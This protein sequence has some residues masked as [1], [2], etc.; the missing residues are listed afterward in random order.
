MTQEEK[1]QAQPAAAVV[2]EAA[3]KRRAWCRIPMCAGDDPSHRGFGK[4]R[5]EAGPA[6]VLEQAIKH[7]DDPQL[8]AGQYG[9]LMIDS[10]FGRDFITRAAGTPEAYLSAV[11]SFSG[12]WE[13]WHGPWGKPWIEVLCTLRAECLRRGIG[14][15]LY[16]G[17][18]WNDP[19]IGEVNLK[20]ATASPGWFVLDFVCAVIERIVLCG[21]GKPAHVVMDEAGVIRGGAP[22]YVLPPASVMRVLWDKCLLGDPGY[23]GIEANPYVGPGYE[24]LSVYSVLQTT[25]HHRHEGQQVKPGPESG[26]VGFRPLEE[27]P[28]EESGGGKGQMKWLA[29]NG[30]AHRPEWDAAGAGRFK[31]PKFVA[32]LILHAQA[33]GAHAMIDPFEVSM[34][35]VMTEAE[36][37]AA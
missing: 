35:A 4:A 5:W 30:E 24:H 29:Y 23:L 19:R 11:P 25:W 20:N 12:M 13:M 16:I 1:Q 31:D 34:L 33:L 28:C 17:N 26:A 36:K 8:G 6:A 32:D 21:S 9:G 7:L 37:A 14:F 10:P 3:V 22:G 2:T 15:G 18:P 27:C